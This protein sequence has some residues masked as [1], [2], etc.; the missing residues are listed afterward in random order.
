MDFKYM[1][2]HFITPYAIPVHVYRHT[3]CS[4]IVIK[5]EPNSG[6]ISFDR[7]EYS[8]LKSSVTSHSGL[9]K[10]L[11]HSFQYSGYSTMSKW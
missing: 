11:E 6:C 5:A 8:P 3:I 4:L 10:R 2:T 1:L 9:T 7:Q